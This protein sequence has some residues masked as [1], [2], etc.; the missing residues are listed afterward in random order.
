MKR[1]RLALES[2]MLR[3]GAGKRSVF[4]PYITAGYPSPKAMP[5]IF[6][7][8]ADSGVRCVEIGVPFSD[9]VADG[10]VIQES[11]HAALVAGVT[12]DSCFRMSEIASHKGLKVIM[13]GYA[14]PFLSMGLQKAAKKMADAGVQG[15][16][17][18]D[19]PMEESLEWREAV[20]RQG[21]ALPLFVAPHTAKERMKDIDKKSTGFIYYVSVSGVTGERTSL[22]VELINRLRWMRATL[23]TPVCVGFGVSNPLQVAQLSP[24]VS[25]IIVGSALIRRLSGW[26]ESANKRREIARWTAAMAGAAGRAIE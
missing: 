17:V 11:T 24:H 3:M 22:P 26:Q 18:P 25:G 19:L 9:P 7:M 4:M 10:P 1:E 21:I 2:F 16:I 15:I 23:D 14:N 20:S 12:P 13:M 5:A 6:S 8:L